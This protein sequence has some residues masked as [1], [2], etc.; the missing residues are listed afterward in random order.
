MF[1]ILSVSENTD[2]DFSIPPTPPHQKKKKEKQ[3]QK[4]K[5]PNRP[6]IKTT[7]EDTFG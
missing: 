6:Q 5:A 3:K 4:T 2:A 7:D 1:Y